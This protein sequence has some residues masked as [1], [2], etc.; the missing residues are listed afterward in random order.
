MLPEENETVVPFDRSV[1]GKVTPAIIGGQGKSGI[2]EAWRSFD[3]AARVRLVKLMAKVMA[4]MLALWV[5]LIVVTLGE[6]HLIIGAKNMKA[7]MGV[8]AGRTGRQ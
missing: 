7:I 8:I 2:V 4:I 6:A 3:W 5:L 1:G